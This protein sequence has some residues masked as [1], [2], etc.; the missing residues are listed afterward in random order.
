[1]LA[2]LVRVVSGAR[3]LVIEAPRGIEEHL[4]TAT[5]AIPFFYLELFLWPDALSVVPAF[6]SFASLGEPP[7]LVAIA[8]LA[9]LLIAVLLVWRRIR[10]TAFCAGWFLLTLVPVTYLAMLDPPVREHHLYLP[11]AGLAT[12][13]ALLAGGLVVRAR[14]A[15]WR[16]LIIVLVAVVVVA[17]GVRTGLRNCDWQDESRLLAGLVAESAGAEQSAVIEQQPLT[18]GDSVSMLPAVPGDGAMRGGGLRMSI[19]PLDVVRLP[20]ATPSPAGSP[21]VVPNHTDAITGGSYATTAPSETTPRVAAPVRTVSL[22]D[23]LFAAAFAHQQ[24][25]RHE[26][27]VGAYEFLLVEDPDHVQGAFNLAYALTEHVATGAD[28]PQDLERAIALLERAHQ[29]APDYSEI[30][31]RLA[32]AYDLLAPSTTV[33]GD[34]RARAVEHYRRYLA[35]D[36]AHPSLAGHASDRLRALAGE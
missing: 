26:P 16:R 25:G 4:A 34:V 31:Y 5:S 22:A 9:V 11:M 35:R 1:V 17:L 7:V 29:L 24:A 27:A 15:A 32:R 6:R 33:P 13:V 12:A 23:S 30:L 3:L 14:G 2:I 10:I 19:S 18:A 28:E 20:D 36:D 21:D 8:V